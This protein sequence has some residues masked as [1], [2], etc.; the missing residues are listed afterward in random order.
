AS[1]AAHLSILEG[2]PASP[3]FMKEIAIYQTRPEVGI[4]NFEVHGDRV[5]IAYYHDG[6]RIVD[7]SNPAQPTE[8]AHYNNWIEDR[9]YGGAFEGAIGIRK[10][11]DLI[12][13]ADLE[14]GLLIFRED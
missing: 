11:G 14:R 4:H 10:V 8:V 2:D 13:V 6:V 1:G 12:Y 3:N 5:Y 9:S 7:L